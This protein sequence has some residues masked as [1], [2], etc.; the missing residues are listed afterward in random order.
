MFLFPLFQATSLFKFYLSPLLL[1][2]APFSQGHTPSSW[3]RAWLWLEIEA[4]PNLC[5]VLCAVSGPL[6]QGT[7]GLSSKSGLNGG[8]PLLHSCPT[9]VRP[10]AVPKSASSCFKARNLHIP[11]VMSSLPSKRDARPHEKGWDPLVSFILSSFCYPPRDG[12]GW[13]PPSCRNLTLPAFPV[14]LASFFPGSIKQ[15]QKFS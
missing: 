6:C 14:T 13:F 1:Q 10:T 5:Q 7:T 12:R 11:L 15:G 4:I 9:P 3:V 2:R 8:S